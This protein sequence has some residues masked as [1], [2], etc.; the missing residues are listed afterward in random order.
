MK[1][2]NR[3]RGGIRES[4]KEMMESEIDRAEEGVCVCVGG[5]G[6]EKDKKGERKREPERSKE[7]ERERD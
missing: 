6:G 4:H 5:G 2:N 7:R 1:K 3:E